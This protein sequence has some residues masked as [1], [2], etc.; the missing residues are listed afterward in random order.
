M[1][2]HESLSLLVKCSCFSSNIHL[3]VSLKVE[4]Y[5]RNILFWC[6]D[7]QRVL[8]AVFSSRNTTQKW[9]NNSIKN[10]QRTWRDK[11]KK[12]TEKWPAGISTPLI[13]RE[14]KSIPLTTS[15][16]SSEAI[17]TQLKRINVD[18][19]VAKHWERIQIGIDIMKNIMDA[20]KEIRNKPNLWS[21]NPCSECILKENEITTLWRYLNSLVHSCMILNNQRMETT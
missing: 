8:M 17:T 11:S 14:C 5:F 2:T 13:I 19:D 3:I 10:G 7:M 16:H 6:I 4:S 15:L 9:K 12:M 1:C 18:E 20:S 21:T